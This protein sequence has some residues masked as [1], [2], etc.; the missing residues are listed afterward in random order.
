MDD[1]NAVVTKA[2]LQMLRF[3][4]PTFEVPGEER[5]GKSPQRRGWMSL[6]HAEV[7]ELVYNLIIMINI[8]QVSTAVKSWK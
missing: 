1:E 2:T 3:C 5:E 8:Y 6:W 7:G 4:A